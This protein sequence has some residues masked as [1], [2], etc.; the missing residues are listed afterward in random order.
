MRSNKINTAT[1]NND[2]L[3]LDH[4]E[5]IRQFAATVNH[6]IN[7]PLT[8]IIGQ[9]EISEIAYENGMETTLR[10]SLQNIIK[11]AEKIRYITQK[12]ENLETL[13]TVDYA[14]YTKILNL[15]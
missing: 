7:N 1:N 15:T 8:S 11:E 2:S 5:L 12:L 10:Q 14:G 6:E 3:Y 13:E 9:A 4:L